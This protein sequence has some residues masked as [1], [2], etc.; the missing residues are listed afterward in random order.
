MKLLYWLRSSGMWACLLAAAV[1]MVAT[2]AKSPAMLAIGWAG[3]LVAGVYAA[4]Y[5]PDAKRAKVLQ[6][7]AQRAKAAGETS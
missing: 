4:R 3:M 1:A 6:A 5:C 2:I 7:H